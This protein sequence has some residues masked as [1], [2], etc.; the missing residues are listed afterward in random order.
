MDESN[1]GFSLSPETMSALASRKLKIA[2]DV[3]AND[4]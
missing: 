4:A 2:F 1:E 3:Y